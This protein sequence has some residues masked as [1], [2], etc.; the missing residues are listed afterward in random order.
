MITQRYTPPTCTLEITAIQPWLSRLRG[1]SVLEDVQFHLSFDDPK[2]P[3]EEYITLSGDR[4]Q[5]ENLYQVVHQY[6]QQFLKTP[7]RPNAIF[8]VSP[9]SVSTPDTDI[10]FKSDGV[11]YHDLFLGSLMPQPTSYDI[12]LSALQLFDLDTAL[13]DCVT[14][15]AR[16]STDQT[17]SSPLLPLART[18]LTVLI[19]IGALTGLI[20]LIN[21][22]QQ[23]PT[24]VAT[25]ETATPEPLS[26]PNLVSPPTLEPL[27]AP[28]PTPPAPETLS[29][30]LPSV[31]TAPLPVPSPIF[32]NAATPPSPTP[33]PQVRPTQNE[34][35]II[36]NEPKPSQSPV[37][38]IQPAAAPTPSQ[39]NIPPIPTTP[40][41]P[42]AVGQIPTIIQ[43]PPLQNPGTPV[44]INTPSPSPEAEIEDQV[45]EE[46][47]SYLAQLNKRPQTIAA[48]RE[49]DTTLF[50]QIPQVA[51]VR[52]YFQ[53]TWY[54]P[55]SLQRSLQYS[56]QLN[57]DGSLQSITPIGQPSVNRLQQVKFPTAEV[58]FVSSIEQGKSVKIRVILQPSGRVQTFLETINL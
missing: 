33:I 29:P 57:A 43:L 1:E 52:N 11:L 42:I 53:Q 30:N 9:S 40:S 44:A 4:H 38:P 45:E 8:Q 27:P 24:P 50:D 12:H 18:V 31:T 39:P 21:T 2:L 48:S 5:L 10:H 20:K 37:A 41:T 55:K 46:P 58:P 3:K 23:E 32:P 6:V 49:E 28:T 7:A 35:V 13:Q 14:E 16:R 54:P 51:E 47:V 36:P 56:L 15:L 19:G 22:S 26:P 25:T 34:F 17:I